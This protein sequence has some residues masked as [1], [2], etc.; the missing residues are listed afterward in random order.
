MIMMISKED[1]EKIRKFEDIR[2]R[3]YYCS[4]QEV[5]ELYNRILNKRVNPT[6]CG[7]CISQRIRELVDALNRYEREQ[8]KLQ[9]ALKKE[10]PTPV[11]EEENKPARS[12]KTNK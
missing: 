3:G 9:E 2:S 5:T 4:G 12:K 1:S 7:S 11:K 8:E 10:E 6:N